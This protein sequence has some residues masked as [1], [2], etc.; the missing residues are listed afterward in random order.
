MMLCSLENIPFVF[1]KM[2]SVG[3]LNIRSFQRHYADFLSDRSL[4]NLDVLCL[5]ETH[6]P[7]NSSGNDYPIPGHH[8]LVKHSCHGLASLI[9]DSLHYRQAT[10]LHIPSELEAFGGYIEAKTPL[11]VAVIYRPSSFP[12]RNFLAHL[13]TPLEQVPISH[14]RTVITGDFNM[15][16][17]LSSPNAL[18]R[19][20]DEFQLKQYVNKLTHALGSSLYLMFSNEVI[21]ADVFPV[22]YLDHHVLL[23]GAVVILYLSN[24]TTY[25]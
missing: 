9:K 10:E 3:R 8:V 24:L 21:A 5:T 15:D 12:R 23:P 17:T 22:P 19:I 16:Q 20:M 11:F 25:K 1:Y 14:Y 4:H 18:I 6:T 13:R 2:T 7:E